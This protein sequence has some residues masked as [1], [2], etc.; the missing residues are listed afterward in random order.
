MISDRKLFKQKRA[1]QMEAV[2]TMMKL[3]GYEKQFKMISV[4]LEKL[5]KVR[6]LL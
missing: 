3:E 4:V 1:A 6:H 5:F 2:K